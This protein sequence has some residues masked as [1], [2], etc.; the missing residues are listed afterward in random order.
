MEN[1]SYGKL[2]QPTESLAMQ[3]ELCRE[4]RGAGRDLIPAQMNCSTSSWCH[5][6]QT[7]KK[8]LYWASKL[9]LDP[10][11]LKAAY[12]SYRGQRLTWKLSFQL[13][14]QFKFCLNSTSFTFFTFWLHDILWQIF[15]FFN[16]WFFNSLNLTSPTTETYHHFPLIKFLI[17][18]K[19]PG[20]IVKLSACSF[21]Y[22]HTRTPPLLLL[23]SVSPRWAGYLL[24]LNNK[25]NWDAPR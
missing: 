6:K 2:H 23:V 14:K 22:D 19:Q 11:S 8:Q 24:L 13:K 17:S 10:D 3:T 21:G 1:G 7:P 4:K 5:M 15:E 20:L 9:G 16:A 12:P 18:L 25:Q